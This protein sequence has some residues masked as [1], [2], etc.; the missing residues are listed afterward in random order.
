MAGQ[1]ATAEEVLKEIGDPTQYSESICG[2]GEPMI[3][4][5][6]LTLKWK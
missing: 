2:F 6:E 1:G 3:K 4:L 5:N